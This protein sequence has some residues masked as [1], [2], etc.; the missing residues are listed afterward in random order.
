M[1]ARFLTVRERSDDEERGNARMN[2]AVLDQ[3][4]DISMNSFLLKYACR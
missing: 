3:S 4:G 1:G 2:L